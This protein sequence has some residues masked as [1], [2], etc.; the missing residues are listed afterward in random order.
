MSHG[1]MHTICLRSS[2]AAQLDS[3]TFQWKLQAANFSTPHSKAFL[4][5]ELPMSQW[6]IEESYGRVYVVER[7]VIAPDRRRLNVHETVVRRSAMAVD[8]TDATASPR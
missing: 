2:D 8:V 6:S 4:S 7:I 1:G 5:I 3:G